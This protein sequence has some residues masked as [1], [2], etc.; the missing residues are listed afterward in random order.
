[1]GSPRCPSDVEGQ[2]KR[3]E[4]EE[5]A[6]L[7]RWFYKTGLMVARQMAVTM[8][9][10]P[11]TT[12]PTAHY[13]GLEDSFDLPPASIVWIG[14][15]DRPFYQRALWVQRFVWHDPALK[16]TQPADGYSLVLTIRDI[17]GFIAVLDTRQSRG[18]ENNPPPFPLGAL[19]P[20][21]LLRI[22]PSSE[23]YGILWPPS[24]SFAL[25][26]V[27]RLAKTF[28]RAAARQTS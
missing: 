6:D 24:E 27:Q 8:D 3:L 23:H 9:D 25:D 10:D 28:E 16:G 26:E 12:L 1:M 20:G 22:W 17:V 18:S 21:K 4:M 2:P 19:G 5:Q 7:A 14:R 15:V 13:A 11:S